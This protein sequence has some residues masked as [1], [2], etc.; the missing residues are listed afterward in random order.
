MPMNLVSPDEPLELSD[1]GDSVPEGVVD[2]GITRRDFFKI[3]TLTGAAAVSGTNTKGNFLRK[4]V[5]GD[6]SE[7]S[8][9]SSHSIWAFPWLNRLIVGFSGEASDA[10]SRSSGLLQASPTPTIPTPTPTVIPTDNILPKLRTVSFGFHGGGVTDIGVDPKTYPGTN[11]ILGLNEV[12][13]N[14]DIYTIVITQLVKRIDD[15]DS[16]LQEE[17]TPVSVKFIQTKD[18]PKI[19]S[20]IFD[21]AKEGSVFVDFRKSPSTA[22]DDSLKAVAIILDYFGYVGGQDDLHPELTE[23]GIVSSENAYLPEI[24][25]T[26]IVEGQDGTISTVIDGERQIAPVLANYTREIVTVDNT[27]IAR[28]PEFF[29]DRVALVGKSIVLYTEK[30][31]VMAIW[32][33]DS[34]GIYD[35]EGNMQSKGMVGVTAEAARELGYAKADMNNILL[36][37]DTTFASGKDTR[38]SLQDIV[39]PSYIPSGHGD[40][41]LVMSIPKSSYLVVNAE[42]EKNNVLPVN[43]SP[44]RSWGGAYVD[45]GYPNKYAEGMTLSIATEEYILSDHKAYGFGDLVAIVNEIPLKGS[46]RYAVLSNRLPGLSILMNSDVTLHDYSMTAD[47]NSYQYLSTSNMRHSQGNFVFVLSN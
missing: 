25:G 24:S 17:S 5:E 6:F 40:K 47:D 11:K 7:S 34:A 26:L 12:V 28:F 35:A 20:V 4:V 19:I 33:P 10:S 46:A 13:L 38:L 32:W 15:S 27:V 36:Y 44:Q 3:I 1:L 22:N 37:A 8:P 23:F 29:Q 2:G 14:E 21:D 45:I 39:V 31:K 41:F 43:V 42:G 30:E 18:G 9:I 16:S